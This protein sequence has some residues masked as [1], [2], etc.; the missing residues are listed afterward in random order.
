MK[1]TKV[2]LVSFVI[3]LGYIDFNLYSRTIYVPTDYLYIQKAI[4]ASENGDIIVIEEGIYC[5]QFNFKGKA[6][7]V[8]SRYLIDKDTSHISQTIID[9][10][11]LPNDSATMVYFKNGE[12]S[13]SVLLGLTLQNGRGSKGLLPNN[14]VCQYGGAISLDNSG[15]K[16][17]KNR[18]INCKCKNQSNYSSGGA[19]DCFRIPIT[20]TVIIK[21]NFI[22]NNEIIGKDYSYGAGINC[23]AISGS[24]IIEKNIIKGNTASTSDSAFSSN[25]AGISIKVGGSNPIIISNNFITYNSLLEGKATFGAGIF[26]HAAN[27]KILNNVITNNKCLGL[28]GRG[29]GIAVGNWREIDSLH[30][31]VK[32]T[33]NTIIKNYSQNDG[34]GILARVLDMGQGIYYAD[35]NVE[36]TNNVLRKNSSAEELHFCGIINTKTVEYCNIEGGFNGVGNIDIEPIFCD[37]IFCILSK[38]DS[39]CI[40]LGNPNSMYNDLIKNGDVI[41]PARG[42]FRNDIGAFGGPHSKWMDI[43]SFPADAEDSLTI[44]NNISRSQ[45][46]YFLNQNYP[47]PFNPSTTIKYSIPQDLRYETLPTGRQVQDVRLVVY[48]ILGREVATIVNQKQKPGNYEVEWNAKE[49]PSGVYFY[50]LTTSSFS[51][52]KKMI[53][54]R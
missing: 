25:G 3:N 5:Q 4:D 12:D 13:N 41:Y 37:T 24:L 19:I 2:L 47:N 32:I 34:T 31:E 27:A 30:Y 54:L 9:G 50:K 21:D 18:I 7:T 28:I 8:G 53:L 52:T 39:S 49:Y 16:I 35:F 43:E 26:L 48:D 1:L 15:G 40:D 51:Q 44:I 17:I 36:I 33:N 42:T 23:E 46:K 20:K 45:L 10:S 6:I 38:K 14:H 29:G 22:S 11:F